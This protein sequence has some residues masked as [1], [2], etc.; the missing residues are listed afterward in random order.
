[1]TLQDPLKTDHIVCLNVEGTGLGQWPVKVPNDFELP[2][3]CLAL[4]AP[5]DHYYLVF[6]P[7]YLDIAQLAEEVFSGLRAKLPLHW[8]QRGTLPTPDEATPLWGK[9]RFY[10]AP[11]RQITR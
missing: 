1:M 7:E 10:Q 5:N 3:P 2:T 9:S 11:D 4:W 8:I 6:V